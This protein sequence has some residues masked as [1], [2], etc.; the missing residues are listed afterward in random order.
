MALGSAWPA[1][2]NVDYGV[3]VCVSPR[4]A[5]VGRQGRKR[6]TQ[7][8]A[9]QP[10]Q[11]LAAPHLRTSKSRY[12]RSASRLGLNYGLLGAHSSIWYIHARVC[13]AET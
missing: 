3:C 11:H 10:F 9:R 2:T 5:T 6:E 7:P 12:M 4:Q 13:A 1:R 8:L